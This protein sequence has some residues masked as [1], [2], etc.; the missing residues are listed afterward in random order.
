MTARR[1]LLLALGLLAVP[2]ISRS[3]PKGGARVGVLSGRSRQGAIDAGLHGAFLQGMQDLGYV[4]GRNVHYEWRYAAGRYGE[5]RRMAE[6]LVQLK[7]DVIVAEGASSIGP[8]RQA[9]RTIPIVMSTSGDPVGAGFVVSLARP[10]GNTTGLTSSGVETTLKRLELLVAAVPG[11]TR[12]A[13]LTN[14]TGPSSTAFLR[15]AQLAAPKLNVQVIALQI[16]SAEELEAAFS[17]MARE[18]AGALMVPPDAMFNSQRRQ[19]VELAAKARIPAMYALR[20]YSAIGGLLVY[21]HD[22]AEQSRRAATYVDKILKGAKPGDLPV[23]QPR[24][25]LLV[26]LRT[27]KTLGLAIPQQILMRADEVI[28]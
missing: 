21:G 24:L 25:A 9:T 2:G 10:G 8:A 3:Q 23:E 20:E 16:S 18:K 1:Q 19:I 5:L 4:E 6:E 15:E 13:L 12:V 28:R 17:A 22:V 7:V 14:R 26:N 11:L 27:A